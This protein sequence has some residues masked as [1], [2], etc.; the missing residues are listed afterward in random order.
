MGLVGLVWYRVSQKKHSYKI[1][2]FGLFVV[3][4]T[5]LDTDL[6]TFGLFGRFW[7]LWTL[8]DAFGLG[9]LDLDF[10]TGTFGLGLLDLDFWTW[11]F[12][13]GLSDLDFRTW[14]FGLGLSDLDFRTW[15]F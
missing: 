4:W 10:W 3:F 2:G 1:F 7:S 5:P 8:L 13:L 9:L 15:T 14:T 12:G 6:D 11:T